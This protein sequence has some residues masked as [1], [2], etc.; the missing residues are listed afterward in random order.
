LRLLKLSQYI[1]ELIRAGS[2]STGHAKAI[3]AIPD[4]ETQIKVAD[5]VVAKLLSVRETEA[6]IAAMLKR[7]SADGG[8]VK[9]RGDDAGH[10]DPNVRAAEDRLC[11]ALGTKVKIVRRGVRGR[12]EIEFHSDDELDR[13]FTV[14]TAARD[15]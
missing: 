8:A 1:Q 2:I 14:L 9:R 15:H 13:L 7:S 6:L 5:E 10:G 3:L 11:R 4:A 12:I